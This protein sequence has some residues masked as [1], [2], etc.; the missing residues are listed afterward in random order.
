MAQH[1]GPSVT[2]T[3]QASSALSLPADTYIYSLTQLRHS[4]SSSLTTA[5]VASPS[6][7]VLFDHSTLRP[8]SH[9]PKCHSSV[10]A[11]STTGDEH[12]LTAGRDGLVKLWDT[13][14]N[15]PS[16]TLHGEGGKGFSA[17]AGS[18]ALVAAGTE[19]DREGPSD[20]S[21]CLW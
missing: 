19:N 9:I 11:L 10:T 7:L 5:C 13:R 15:A 3:A 17:V 1:A 4:S 2:A 20:V 16:T 14:S 6:S 8:I 18:G 12:L 21:V